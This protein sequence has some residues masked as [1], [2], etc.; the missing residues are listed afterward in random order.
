MS[1]LICSGDEKHV[2]VQTAQIWNSLVG[3]DGLDMDLNSIL[4]ME[5]ASLDMDL[6]S[7]V[8]MEQVSLDTELNGPTWQC[9]GGARQHVEMDLLR[10]TI[11]NFAEEKQ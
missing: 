2:L 6:S 10:V 3:I 5:Q 9:R 11:R 8:Y 1:L 4:C 7:L